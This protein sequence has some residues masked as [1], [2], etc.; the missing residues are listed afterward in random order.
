MT[1]PK[2]ASSQSGGWWAKITSTEPVMVAAVALSL[3][4]AV[5]ITAGKLTLADVSGFV[6][7]FGAVLVIVGPVL[8]GVWVR[9]KVTPSEG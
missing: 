3:V 8:I 2:N 6:E 7:T 9:S 1:A 5:A 4:L